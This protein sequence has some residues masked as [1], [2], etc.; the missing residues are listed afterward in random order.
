[1][2]VLSR[3]KGERIV[4]GNGD[5]ILEVVS[6]TGGR[7][8]IGIQAPKDVRVVR[9]EILEVPSLRGDKRGDVSDLAEGSSGA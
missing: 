5:V 2:L 8:R 7:V 1:M 4:I 9:H 6:I 3:K